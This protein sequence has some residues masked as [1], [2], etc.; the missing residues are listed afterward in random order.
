MTEHRPG[1]GENVRGL[2][3][4]PLAP[5][6]VSVLLQGGQP[7]VCKSDCNHIND[8]N[9]TANPTTK[10]FRFLKVLTRYFI[11]YSLESINLNQ[12][13]TFCKTAYGF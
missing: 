5:V 2:N 13:G 4:G 12:Y 8:G 3:L 7:K 10:I 9:M 11:L 6:L 1:C